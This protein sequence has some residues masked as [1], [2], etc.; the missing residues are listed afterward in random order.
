M[1]KMIILKIYW[2]IKVTFSCLFSVVVVCLICVNGVLWSV[3]TAWSYVVVALSC[4][5]EDVID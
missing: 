3:A 1:G 4:D 5:G 2:K